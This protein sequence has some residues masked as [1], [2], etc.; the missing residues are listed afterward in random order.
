MHA[1]ANGST[2]R[3]MD[4]DVVVIM[5][6]AFLANYPAADVCIAFGTGKNFM[7]YSYT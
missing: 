1:L 4:T 7:Y 3:T 2:M 5:H 6:H